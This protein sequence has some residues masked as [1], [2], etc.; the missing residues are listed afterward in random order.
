M[1]GK[2]RENPPFPA[3][4][5]GQ[6]MDDRN[7][8]LLMA[9]RSIPHPAPR[10]EHAQKN[11]AGSRTSALAQVTHTSIDDRPG[12]EREIDRLSVAQSTAQDASTSGRTKRD[13][14]VLGNDVQH[15]GE[16]NV[17]GDEDVPLTRAQHES[18]GEKE[19][20]YIVHDSV[21]ALHRKSMLLVRLQETYPNGRLTMVRPFV[22]GLLHQ[23]H[24]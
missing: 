6:N 21:L 15:L 16:S 7:G 13:R 2:V 11:S 19:E 23:T 8:G 5:T 10:V 4:N 18:F 20:E 12:E 22:T 24:F 1:Q 9:S 14:P 17:G 3:D